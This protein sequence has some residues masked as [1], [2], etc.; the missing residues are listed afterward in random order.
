MPSISSNFLSISTLPLSLSPLS[1]TNSHS[2]PFTLFIFSLFHFPPNLLW[3]K[4]ISSA[5]LGLSESVPWI[6]KPT[7]ILNWIWSH[8]FVPHLLC[9][10]L[11]LT[12]SHPHLLKFLLSQTHVVTFFF[13]HIFFFQKFI[14]LYT[15]LFLLNPF[16]APRFA[17]PSPSPFSLISRNRHLPHATLPSPPLSLNPGSYVAK[18][19]SS[20]LIGLNTI[21]SEIYRDRVNKAFCF[22]RFSSSPTITFYLILPRFTFSLH[23]IFRI[24]SLFVEC[25]RSLSHKE[26]TVWLD[27]VYKHDFWVFK[28]LKHLEMD[29]WM[30]R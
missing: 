28:F 8:F 18:S 26:I 6:D 1:V 27:Y 22:I 4:T 9:C 29:V 14:F 30:D 23:S 24:F 15:S 5:V 3:L 17:I 19:D 13:I 21:I 16:S 10:L 7:L 25:V 12:L 2:S 11:F 20:M